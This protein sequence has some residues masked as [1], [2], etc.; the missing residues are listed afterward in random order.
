MGRKCFRSSPWSR[1]VGRS[2]G[3]A[4][5]SARFADGVARTKPDPTTIESKIKRE[6]RAVLGWRYEELVRAG[7]A[8]REAMIL[9][10]RGDI[11][12]HLAVELVSRGC[13]TPTAMRILL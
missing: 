13:P 3:A 1:T 9:A 5:R 10:D 8:E 7:Y 6:E 11:D 12:L 4:R 2:G